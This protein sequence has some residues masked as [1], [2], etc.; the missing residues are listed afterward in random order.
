MVDIDPGNEAGC[1]LL[2]GLNYSLAHRLVKQH[3]M[4]DGSRREDEETNPSLVVP[5]KNLGVAPLVQGT[6]MVLSA[7][8]RDFGIT[9]YFLG[10][11]GRR[12]G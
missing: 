5:M 6:H 7:A 9:S 10:S 3:E 11:P 12:P 2:G 8:H 4:F 1:S